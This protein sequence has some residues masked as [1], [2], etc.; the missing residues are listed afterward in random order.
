M[1]ESVPISL[2]ECP[3]C[4]QKFSGIEALSEHYTEL[5]T[6]VNEEEDSS[7]LS[8]ATIDKKE[9]KKPSSQEFIKIKTLSVSEHFVQNENVVE[10]T[11]T[12]EL[13]KDKFPTSQKK[14]AAAEIV[15]SSQK[16]EKIQQLQ[17]KIKSME[18]K[19]GK[20]KRD[21]ME[22]IELKKNI[23]SNQ[24]LENSLKGLKNEVDKKYQEMFDLKRMVLN[25][26]E[27]LEKEINSNKKEKDRNKALTEEIKKLKKNQSELGKKVKECE[28]KNGN[29]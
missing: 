22:L 28:S 25:A 1:E 6:V 26:E 7:P 17:D 3:E 8:K 19:F 23:E 11:T 9:K 4:D 24:N 29:G 13:E 2:E 5:H 20:F 15:S 16:A 21:R 14:S 12:Q 18:D 10:K 27:Q